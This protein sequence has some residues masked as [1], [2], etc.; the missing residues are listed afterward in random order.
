MIPPDSFID[1]AVRGNA[2]LQDGFYIVLIALSRL[3][4]NGGQKPP[5]I[6]LLGPVR[7]Y[8]EAAVDASVQLSGHYDLR[9]E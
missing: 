4:H 3:S 7:E 1:L 2:D 8:A 6:V 9:G 5:D